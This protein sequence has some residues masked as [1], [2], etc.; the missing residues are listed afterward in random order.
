MRLLFTG[1]GTA[2]SYEIRAEQLGKALGA[3][4]KPQAT[5]PDFEACDLAVVIKRAPEAIRRGLASSGRRWVLD[6]LDSWPQPAGNGWQRSEAI[7]WMRKHIA[8]LN[9]TAVIWPN[10]RMRD[11]CDDGRQ[12]FVLPHHA[13]PNQAINPIRE[14]IKRVGYEG[15]PE[16]LD[17]WATVLHKECERRGWHFSVN[18]FALADLD[19][20]VAFRGGHWDGYASEHWKSGVKMTNAHGSG[21]PFVGFPAASYLEMASGAEYWARTPAELKTAFDW[22]EPQST[23]EL[24]ADRFRDSVYT[25]D[26]AAADLKPFLE[27]LC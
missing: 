26:R 18:P 1:K 6:V 9:P 3:T 14:R 15:R 16:Y 25:L 17:G 20:V 23:R 7:A 10:Q 2:G 24:V 22:L 8:A 4:V 27:S 21:T 11:D 5:H 12:G 19:I 13:R